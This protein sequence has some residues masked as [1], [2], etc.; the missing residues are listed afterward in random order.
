MKYPFT[1]RD[2]S[3][4]MKGK[5]GQFNSSEITHLQDITNFTVERNNTLKQRNGVEE[6]YIDTLENDKILPFTHY[7]KQYYFVYDP[8]LNV[9]YGGAFDSVKSAGGRRFVDHFGDNQS[10]RLTSS[11]HSPIDYLSKEYLNYVEL[12]QSEF[13]TTYT[14]GLG[15]E[16]Q[17]DESKWDFFRSYTN[18]PAGLLNVHLN[19]RKMHMETSPTMLYTKAPY[20]DQKIISN[21]PEPLNTYPCVENTFW[22]NRMY[23]MDEDFN[24]ITNEIHFANFVSYDSGHTPLTSIPVED[25]VVRTATYAELQT[26]RE[27]RYSGSDLEYS[28]TVTEQGVFFYH[29]D[30]LL[31]TMFLALNASHESDRILRDYRTLYLNE[32]P[33]GV[34]KTFPYFTEAEY[35]A[36]PSLFDA[37]ELSREMS[38]LNT[39]WLAPEVLP[40]PYSLIALYQSSYG[41][42]Q[43]TLYFYNVKDPLNTSDTLKAIIPLTSDSSPAVEVHNIWLDSADENKALFVSPSLANFDRDFQFEHD[44]EL[45]WQDINLAFDLPF[46]FS[47]SIVINGQH[48]IRMRVMQGTTDHLGVLPRSPYAK[49][50]I[51]K[52]NET[53]IPLKRVTTFD[54]VTVNLADRNADPIMV[55]SYTTQAIRYNSSLEPIAELISDD[56]ELSY[57]DSNNDFILIHALPDVI[58]TYKAS[59]SSSTTSWHGS[60][61]T[62]SS[63]FQF[64]IF[65]D[66]DVNPN[67]SILSTEPFRNSEAIGFNSK[68]Y[69]SSICYNSG[70]L[71]MSAKHKSEKLIFTSVLDY[72]DFSKIANLVNSDTDAV[73]TRG[74]AE[75]LPNESVKSLHSTSTGVQLVTDKSVITI[76]ISSESGLVETKTKSDTSLSGISPATLNNFTYYVADTLKDV[77]LSTFNDRSQTF[78]YYSVFSNINIDDTTDVQTLLTIS[79]ANILIVKTEQNLYVG[80]VLKANTVAWSKLAFGFDVISISTTPHT[81]Y[82]H[83]SE[84]TY[85]LNFLEESD[86]EDGVKASFK[87]LAPAAMAGLMTMPKTNINYTN[88]RLHDIT[89]LGTFESPVKSGSDERK[90]ASIYSSDVVDVCNKNYN[91]IYD[92]IEFSFEGGR[93]RVIYL[94]GSLGG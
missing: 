56:P 79:E 23:V 25:A 1:L 67:F 77:F 7:G 84:H 20:R 63:E 24:I 4:G 29:V 78:E 90:Y 52:F 65:Y 81:L 15:L 21:L 68:K 51:G 72:L 10:T 31:P 42:R 6:L 80:A 54:N 44:G 45:V 83:S 3:G 18:T 38:I 8:L 62:Q 22:W 13:D 93:N 69:F 47:P 28:V 58:I 49:G 94:R 64:K 53:N 9:K 26:I 74:G 33:N 40:D 86:L 48:V 57:I 75:I 36:Q 61:N 17:D 16:P 82:L 73:A 2:F 27:A 71:F 50:A 70:R 91:D 35:A 34:F 30:G 14:V 87:L 39:Y 66:D 37:V 89:L 92:S 76:G 43:L 60:T 41:I 55:F 12:M 59:A 19:L 5:K 85:S 32:I 46:I 11:T 88:M